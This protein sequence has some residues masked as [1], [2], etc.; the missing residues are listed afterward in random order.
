MVNPWKGLKTLTHLNTFGKYRL[1]WI[2]ATMVHSQ[3]YYQ[4][5]FFVSFIR[6]VSKSFQ[7]P[8]FVMKKA[9][10]RRNHC[11]I[12]SPSL[13]CKSNL[14]TILVP[15]GLQ[16]LNL[17]IYYHLLLTW[18]LKDK[19]TYFLMWKIIYRQ[20]NQLQSSI[21]SLRVSSEIAK[22]I[23]CQIKSTHASESYCIRNI[24]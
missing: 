4:N 16:F 19:K 1:I 9:L 15:A 2:M 7:N 6:V 17:G 14:V 8:F 12:E 24:T 20:N 23:N 3:K 18:L 13:D 22:L 11:E 21:A 5:P 10:W